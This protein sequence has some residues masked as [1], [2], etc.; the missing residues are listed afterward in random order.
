[1]HLINTST[2]ALK[3]FTGD[4]AP[5][6]AILSHTWGEEEISFQDMSD[7]D[8][9]RNRRG[10]IKIQWACYLAR[11]DG[12]EY[13]WIDTCCINK[14]SSAELSEAI[15]SMYTWYGRAQ[16]CYA[17]L[18]DVP[19]DDPNNPN[20]P[21]RQLSFHQSR[22]FTRGWTLQELMSPSI[23]IFYDVEWEEIGT[24]ASLRGII[25]Q[26]TGIAEN[27]ILDGGR[28]YS[29]A[30]RMSWASNRQTTRGEDMAYSLMG[31][32][33]VNMPLLYGEGA[34]NAF[35]RLQLEIMKVSNDHSIFAWSAED[36][37][38]D[39]DEYEALNK[40]GG[41]DGDEDSDEDGNVDEDG[42]KAKRGM[43]AY[44]PAEY[45]YARNA[46]MD[47]SDYF[48]YQMTNQ[49]LQIELYLYP[50]P[51]SQD[52]K[53]IAETICHRGDTQFTLGVVLRRQITYSENRSV[54]HRVRPFKPV[55]P[56]PDVRPSP[57]RI[58]IVEPPWNSPVPN[59][60][61]PAELSDYFLIQADICVADHGEFV[62]SRTNK[63][64]ESRPGHKWT[65]NLTTSSNWHVYGAMEFRSR[66][67]ETP[68]LVLIGNRGGN[69][70]G[71]GRDGFWCHIST[72]ADGFNKHLAL[73][74]MLENPPE[75]ASKPI[76][77]KYVASVS[78]RRKLTSDGVRNIALIETKERIY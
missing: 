27:A 18:V 38:A 69:L 59:Q 4:V 58:L 74:S 52:S 25:A 15:N 5:K 48:P 70:N 16:V 78:I 61:S 40:D 11:Q 45:R 6:Y 57:T 14:E 77:D 44:S 8:K 76:N 35:I 22:W 2:I 55:L 75:R 13:I 63:F 21:S 24:K 47:M 53:F 72:D 62:I 3:Y 39:E 17:Y 28:S 41:E 29:I 34:R 73:S 32:F 26:V 50:Y 71:L 10:Y 46:F 31:L 20:P 51:R 42:K 54:Y 12:W 43:L 68:F 30:R 56:Y 36:E 65:L 49:G 1:M 64:W 7:T 67:I 19:P 60:L 37:D 9:I 23:V 33:G 66:S